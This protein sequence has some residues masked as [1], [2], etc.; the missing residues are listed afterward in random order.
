MKEHGGMLLWVF[1]AVGL[2]AGIIID[3]AWRRL[4]KP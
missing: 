3:G 2:G 1:G 4:T